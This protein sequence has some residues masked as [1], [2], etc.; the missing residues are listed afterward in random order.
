MK[1]VF[2][3]S[4]DIGVPS[5]S[6]LLTA[7]QV[8][9]SAVVTQPDRAAGRGLKVGFSRV[10]QLAVER[11]VPVLQPAKVR[12]P[13]AVAELAAFGP[14]LLVVVAY[15]Q[16]LPQSLLGVPRFG[17]LNLHASL[18][19]RHRGASPVHAALLCGDER[20]GVTAMWMD[21][22]LDTGDML[23]ARDCA[24]AADETAG[25]LHD[26]LADLAAV[27][28]EE[29]VGLIGSGQAPRMPQDHSRATYAGKIDRGL[30]RVDWTSG[31]EEIARKVRSLH[32]W[33]GSTMEIVLANGKRMTVKLHRVLAEA[34]AAEAGMMVGE[35]AFGCGGGGILKVLELQPPG[36]RRLAA[37]EFLRGHAVVGAAV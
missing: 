36:G 20:T 19:P 4:G 16:I 15:G 32:P 27:V 23:C 21:A 3:G 10:K 34:G 33:P 1:V 28:L 11:G 35:L 14:D 22:G 31:A 8:E 30:G 37:A 2:L 9:V 7:G 18:L 25:G 5:L 26:R 12:D 6:W 13:A 17:A 29:A 24:I